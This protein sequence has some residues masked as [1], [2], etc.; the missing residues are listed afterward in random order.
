MSSSRNWE[1]PILARQMRKETAYLRTEQLAVQLSFW[2]LQ[3]SKARIVSSSAMTSIASALLNFAWISVYSAIWY[4]RS[5]DEQFGQ[6]HWIANSR[7]TPERV[8]LSHWTLNIHKVR[9]KVLWE[10]DLKKFLS[11][12]KPNWVFELSSKCWETFL[13]RFSRRDFFQ[14]R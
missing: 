13:D 8:V 12:R 10:N 2:T 5:D 7:A 6:I 14:Y 11:I 4:F 9:K 1:M 3:S